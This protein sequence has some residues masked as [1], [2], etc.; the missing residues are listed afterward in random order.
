MPYCY[1]T[2]SLN[3]SGVTANKC[4]R[5]SGFK[6]WSANNTGSLRCVSV[7]HDYRWQ[8]NQSLFQSRAEV[9]F[10]RARQF[11]EYNGKR[12]SASRVLCRSGNHT[13]RRK[14]KLS[15]YLVFLLTVYVTVV[16][17]F[18]HNN[19]NIISLLGVKSSHPPTD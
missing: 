18:I 3:D 4:A 6:S 5:D 17:I 14:G 12:G 9:S 7:I 8:L 1:Y 16:K 10:P 2:G 11:S 15:N 19:N 13:A